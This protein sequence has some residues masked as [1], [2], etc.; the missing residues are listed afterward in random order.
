MGFVSLLEDI[1]DRADSDRHMM[2]SWRRC[3][4]SDGRRAN[5]R[6]VDNVL[7][8][9][10]YAS[11][12]KN[13][14]DAI[15]SEGDPFEWPNRL[16]HRF[17]SHYHDAQAVIVEN[18][19]KWSTHAD[20]LKAL[21][22]ILE[23]M[24]SI[25]AH[26]EQA[27]GTIKDV[28]TAMVRYLAKHPEYGPLSVTSLDRAIKAIEHLHDHAGEIERDLTHFLEIISDSSVLQQMSEAIRESRDQLLQIHSRLKE[29]FDRVRE[30]RE[31]AISVDDLWK[32]FIR[33]HAL[34]L[35]PL[36]A[37]P[38]ELS[39]LYLNTEQQALVGLVTK[40]HYRIQGA[41]GSGKTVVL[42][43]RAV[44]LAQRN[45]EKRVR[46]ITMNRML[47]GYLEGLCKS[48]TRGT[49]PPNLEVW[50]FYDLLEEC[51]SLFMDVSEHRMLKTIH[52]ERDGIPYT[53]KWCEFFGGDKHK[54]N[55]VFTESPGTKKPGGRQGHGG[56]SLYETV[57]GQLDATGFAVSHY[58]YSEVQYLQGMAL[59]N[60]R[61][62]RY[63]HAPRIGRGVQ[64][65]KR[66]RK[67]LLS[68]CKIWED[69]LRRERLWDASFMATTASNRFVD[70]QGLEK[71]RSRFSVDILL[72]DELQDFSTIEI[73]RAI[74]SNRS[75]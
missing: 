10:S 66:Y 4:A 22:A 50:C 8:Q 48:L 5:Q 3:I 42:A 63:L 1:S 20:N 52:I 14:L 27:I 70:P 26:S 41:S 13:V 17:S 59:S 34:V 64:L 36:R 2:R 18:R 15:A 19:G 73:C 32:S 38:E 39:H 56:K 44:D 55:R 75:G 71:I 46:F 31:I 67:V 21:H 47:A 7:A 28:E 24:G 6:I 49:I 53:V 61:K 58:L 16:I 54:P 12:N 40:G 69:R 9:L 57:R 51:I 30:F 35:R 33:S 23:P 37:P 62:E 25:G 74:A 72:V 65:S 43:Q 11:D 68:A 29:D 60:D 45:P